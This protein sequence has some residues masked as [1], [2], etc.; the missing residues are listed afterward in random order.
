MQS[1]ACVAGVRVRPVSV[2]PMNQTA[3]AAVALVHSW[4]GRHLGAYIAVGAMAVVIILNGLWMMIGTHS[5]WRARHFLQLKRPHE[6][7]LTDLALFCYR[8]VGL[9]CVLIGLFLPVWVHLLIDAGR[10]PR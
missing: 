5:W 9:V 10:D 1:S 2:V 7:E 3:T 6:V 4:D 8:L